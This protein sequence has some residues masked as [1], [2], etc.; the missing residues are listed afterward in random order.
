MGNLIGTNV[1]GI[2]I[3]IKDLF[4]LKGLILMVSL[5]LMVV[6]LIVIFG[7]ISG[8]RQIGNTQCT[9]NNSS[10]ETTPQYVVDDYYFE[11]SFPVSEPYTFHYND[12][13]RFSML[14]I[15]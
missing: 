8:E 12:P 11:S 1:N 14:C 4:H 5:L 3:I 7:H 2:M 10:T 15:S 6:T 9:C 13:L